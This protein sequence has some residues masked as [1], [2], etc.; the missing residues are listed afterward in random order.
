MCWEVGEQGEGKPGVTG[1]GS[2]WESGEERV[3][4]GI[5]KA[6]GARKKLHMMG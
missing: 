2:L 4:R 1:A 3:G 5:P 6:V